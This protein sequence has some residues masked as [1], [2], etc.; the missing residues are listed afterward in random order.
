M[1]F[2]RFCWKLSPE[3]MELQVEGLEVLD[4]KTNFV[5]APLPSPPRCQK[6]RPPCQLLGAE[7][8]RSGLKRTL[9]LQCGFTPVEGRAD[10]SGTRVQT[11]VK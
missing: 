2:L 9:L 4:V 7:V 11:E 1:P 3:G 10:T 8:L 6:W 5:S